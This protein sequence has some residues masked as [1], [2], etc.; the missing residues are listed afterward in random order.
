MQC[1]KLNYF[2]HTVLCKTTDI[3]T[4]LVLICILKMYPVMVA[5]FYQLMETI[6]M[7]LH[8]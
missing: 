4:R 3:Q 1:F 5:S 8:N 7:V 6:T 2:R